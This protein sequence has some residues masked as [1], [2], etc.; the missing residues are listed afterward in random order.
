M[1]IVF[2]LVAVVVGLA[3][4]GTLSYGMVALATLIVGGV[5]ISRTRPPL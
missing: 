2:L 1:R 3:L 4:A 5:A